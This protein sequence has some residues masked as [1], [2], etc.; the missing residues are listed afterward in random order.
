MGK[1]L[2]HLRSAYYILIL[3]HHIFI[4]RAIENKEVKHTSSCPESDFRPVTR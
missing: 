3:S 2:K 1:K 4:G